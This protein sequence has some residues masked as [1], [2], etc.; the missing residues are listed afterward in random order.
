M[1]KIIPIALICLLLLTKI[2][3]SSS[4]EVGVAESLKGNMSSIAYD[5]TSNIVKF[6]IEF[7]NTGSIGY[8]ARIKDEI[9]DGSKLVF[10]GWSQEQSLMPGERKTFNIYWFSSNEGKY[11]SKFK[12][13]FGNEILEYKKFEFSIGKS[14]SPENV[15]EISNLRTY[16]NHIIFD[17]QSREDVKNVI[18]MPDKYI[19]GWIF[20]QSVIANLSKN[21]SKVV[22]IN[23]YPTLWTPLNISLSI[24]SDGG[25]YY[26]ERL[27]EMKKN[28]GLTWLFYYIIDSF[29]TAF[30]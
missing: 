13:Y 14:I 23:Y 15:F 17:L 1:K 20:E 16:D 22:V 12:A 30:K 9:Y 21:T 7:Y 6:S 3:Y 11:Y 4:I 10:N 24:A 28:E 8:K 5:N 2:S 18:I 26:S 25:K 29:R 27:V 19:Y